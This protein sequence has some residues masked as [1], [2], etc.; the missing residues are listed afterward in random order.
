[1]TCT[2]ALFPAPTHLS[3]S[4]STMTA[5]TAAT[6]DSSAPSIGA[7]GTS[8]PP[9]VAP[10]AVLRS[11]RH[12]LDHQMDL[13]RTTSRLPLAHRF[14]R[15]EGDD[16]VARNASRGDFV[17]RNHRLVTSATT[18]A[19]APTHPELLCTPR[20]QLP[21]PHAEAHRVRVPAGAYAVRPRWRLDQQRTCTRDGGD[22]DVADDRSAGVFV[23]WSG[24][25][26]QPRKSSVHNRHNVRQR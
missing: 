15:S 5:R 22:D 17:R 19:P 2:G 14:A 12:L 6:S 20:P 4:T 8:A 21:E 25:A 9:P 3:T 7:T 10:H 26:V 18:R 16:A 13:C 24:G 11:H 1:M 23:R